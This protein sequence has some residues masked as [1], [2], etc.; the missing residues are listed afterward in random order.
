[1]EDSLQEAGL[2]VKQVKEMFLYVGEKVQEN[3]PLLTRLDSA[4]GDGDHGIGMSVGFKKAAESLGQKE[5]ATINDIFKTIGMS[6]ISSMGG[7]SGVIFGTLFMGGVKGLE[8]QQ[9]L[10]LP[11]LANI[12]EKSLEAIKTR[13]KASLGDKT[14][15]DA[16]EPAVNALKQSADQHADILNGIKA[17]E[18]NA[19]K[20]VE[21]SKKY[22]AKFGRAKTLGERA[23][24]H[25]DAGATTVWII[26]K[27]MRE[28]I[29]NVSVS[30]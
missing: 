30:H 4:I 19:E 24:G 29:E 16:L 13:G 23:I 15:I 21:N 25:Q 8:S 1:M 9:E 11:L 6:M 5:L 20:G 26:F 10:D 17:A 7:A 27:S 2:N 14:M 28:W 18:E 22:I 12:F 3:K